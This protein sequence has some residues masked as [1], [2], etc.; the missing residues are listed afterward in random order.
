MGNQP[1]M[2]NLFIT[3]LKRAWVFLKP[4]ISTAILILLL[5]YTGL[6]SAISYVTG[7][8]LMYTGIMD[9]SARE[10]AILSTF[11]YDFNIRDLNGNVRSANDFRGKTLF[12]NIWATWCAPCRMEMPSIQSLYS[13]VDTTQIVFVMLSVDK[14]GDLGKI[15]TYVREKEFTFPVYTPAG[16]L[17]SLLQVNSIP[18]TMVI[19]PDGRVVSSEAGATNYDTRK[20]RKFLKS[21]TP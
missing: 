18:T 16:S 6:L 13:Q 20:F 9:A 5:H 8:A 12:L 17:P 21:L 2:E 14:P 19:A 4:W 3:H 11:D 7:R 15:K 1:G 10:P